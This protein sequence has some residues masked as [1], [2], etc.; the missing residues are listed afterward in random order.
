MAPRAVRSDPARMIPAASPL[1]LD[2]TGQYLGGPLVGAHDNARPTKAELRRH[3]E[4][5]M[6]VAGH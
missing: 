1:R 3:M 6:R 5:L 4:A 2:T